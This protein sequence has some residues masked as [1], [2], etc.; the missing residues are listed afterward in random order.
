MVKHHTIT[1]IQP[2]YMQIKED[3]L[4]KITAC[5]ILPGEAIPSEM[6]LAN[7]YGVSRLTIRAALLELQRDGVLHSV[8]GKGSYVIGNAV[9]RDLDRLTGFSRSMKELHKEPKNSLIDSYIRCA[10]SYYANIFDIKEYDEI[11]YIKRI[12]SVD[13][14]PLSL[15]EIYIPVKILPNLMNINTNDFSMYDIYDYYNI[16]FTHADQTLEVTT[17]DQNEARLLNIKTEDPVF[18][19]KCFTYSQ[20]EM[21]EYSI[22]Y[23]NPVYTRF[24]SEF[25][26]DFNIYL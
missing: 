4:S 7:L 6:E 23:V 21:I 17:V 14:I 1:H 9:S 2:A 11:H 5:S 20:N 16:A 3:I 25:N 22:S 19:L 10:G 26:K 15:E 12:S 18:L 8:H 24:H 13:K